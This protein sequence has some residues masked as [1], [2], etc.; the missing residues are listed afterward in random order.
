LV[1][2]FPITSDIHEKVLHRKE[3]LPCCI[4]SSNITISLGEELL[5]LTKPADDEHASL[6]IFE[7]AIV[8]IGC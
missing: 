3:L 5:T 8:G 1:T 4:E 2:E 6:R 7:L